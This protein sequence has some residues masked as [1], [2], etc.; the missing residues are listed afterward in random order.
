[1]GRGKRGG[2]C[3]H[4]GEEIGLALTA[5]DILA[6]FVHPLAFAFEQDVAALR[7][8]RDQRRGAHAAEFLGGE[9]HSRIPRMRGEGCHAA[10]DGS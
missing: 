8:G 3:P 5:E 9:E 1:M 10:A 7:E 6:R 4:E 2:I